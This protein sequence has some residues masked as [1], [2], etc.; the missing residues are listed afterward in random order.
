[1]H[2]V[3]IQVTDV[4]GQHAR[5]VTGQPA[6][7]IVHMS[8]IRLQLAAVPGAVAASRAIDGHGDGQT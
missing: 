6:V 4:D 5:V 8:Q 2:A 7:G 3:A 1:M